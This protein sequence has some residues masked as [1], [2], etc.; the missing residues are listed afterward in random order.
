MSTELVPVEFDYSQKNRQVHNL[1]R[2]WEDDLFS[3]I[4][5]YGMGPLP[6]T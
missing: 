1:K 4:R 5:H 6:E 2:N 3:V